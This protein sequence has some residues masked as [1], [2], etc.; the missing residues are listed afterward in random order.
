MSLLAHGTGGSTDLPIPYTYALIG[1]AWALTLTFALVALGWRKP[2]FDPAKPGVALPRRITALVD[3][4]A[5]RAVIALLGLGFTAWVLLAAIGG[6]QNNENALPGT[7]YVLL[8][9]GLPTASVLLGPVWR[10]ISPL[11]TVW[12]LIPRGAKTI[13]Y[14]SNWGYWPAALGLFAFVWLELASPNS[15]SL[16][17][18]KLWLL[19]YAMVMLCGAGLFGRRWFSRGDP[20]EVY[21][22]VA[23]RL[24]P[25]RRDGRRRLIVVGNPFDHLPT[26]PVRPGTVAV[27]AVLLGSTAFDSFSAMPKWRA[28]VDATSA[29]PGGATLARTAGLLGFALIVGISFWLA[30]RATGGVDRDAR[31]K[32]PGR[33]AHSLV[34]I[35]LGYVFAHYLSYLVE[36]GQQTVIRLSD[37]LDR[38]WNLLGLGQ[39]DVS[40]VL[41]M[42]PGVLATIKVTCVVAGHI[43]GVVAA[44]DAA[45]RLLPKGH[46]LTGQLAMML[47][48]VA[49]TFTGLYLLF[50]G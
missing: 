10:L 35:V 24:S 42:H 5:T 11:R 38:G 15:A 26:L 3:A 23:S 47:V 18:I 27:L 29:M 17:A 8:W 28:V 33:L 9:V 12:E 1:A 40:Y 2:R 50:G 45:L 48:M 13:D 32:L 37:P 6:P 31:R 21:S 41:S 7:F 25:L 46:Q 49:Y 20:F 22:V 39:E 19:I 16:T 44:H 36:R 30:A 4:K 14:P 34:P 43:A